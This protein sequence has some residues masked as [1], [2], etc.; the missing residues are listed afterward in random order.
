MSMSAV[1]RD[2]I[3]EQINE[4][5]SASYQYLAMSAYCERQNL[6]GCARWLRIQSHEEY[7]HG[8][9]LFDFMIARGCD[10]AIGSR[11]G[12]GAHRLG[13][14]TYR[15]VMGRAFNLLVRLLV[16][17]G[18]QD[19]QCG[20]KLFTREAARSIMSRARLYADPAAP[21]S[22]PR[23]TAFDVELLVIAR[24]QGL[25][26]CVHPVVWTYGE[27]SKVNPLRDTWTN[28]MDVLRVRWY[29]T[30]GRYR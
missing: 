15:H 20:F 12:Q 2:A 28:L 3:N 18:I 1:V 4:E 11:E 25:K 24:R 9:K 16:L 17:P 7:G 14:P 23:V 21:L 10:V 26:I 6:R 19:T 29:D 22:G 30:R 8:M 5:L 27:Q 13:E